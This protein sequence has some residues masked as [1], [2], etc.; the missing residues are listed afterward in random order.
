[1]VLVHHDLF[2]RGTRRAQS[3]R[4]FCTTAHPLHTRFTKTLGALFLKR[5]CDRTLGTRRL[6]DV[7]RPL[8]VLRDAVRMTE[9]VAGAPAWRSVG[10]SLLVSYEDLY[11]VC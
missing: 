10:S 7:W 4:R 6:P 2:H 5:R 3:H 8:F 11:G 1:V 9:P